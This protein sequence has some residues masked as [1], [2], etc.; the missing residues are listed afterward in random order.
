MSHDAWFT[1]P[2]EWPLLAGLTEA[3]RRDVLAAARKRTFVR[4]EVV[5]HAGDPA[6]SIHLVTDGHLSVRVTLAS[7]DTAL[8]NV[9][10]PGTYFGE[11]ALLRADRVRTAT[12]TALEPAGTLAIN[13]AAFRRLCESRP[14]VEHALTATL[15]DRI[16][17]LSQRL[18]ETMYVGLDRRLYRTLVDLAA[19]YRS[20]DGEIV[21][22]LTQTQLADLTGG[23]R[24]SV[25][26]VLQRLVEQRILTVGRGRV[27]VLDL[28]RLNVKA[29]AGH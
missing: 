12:I 26:Q 22:P 14:Q 11:L 18:L 27:E 23:T 15:A 20:P 21:I 4:N 29:N 3:E 7:G 19:D 17:E 5:C 2:V 16:D 9:L 13:A 24:P 8:I 6:D 28:E 1:R 10:G 25:N